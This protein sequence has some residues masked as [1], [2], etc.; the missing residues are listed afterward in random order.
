M[1]KIFGIVLFLSY[2]L[3]IQAQ[4]GIQ[5]NEGDWKSIVNKAKEQHKLIFIDVF[6]SWCGPCKRMAQDVF[7]Q[8]SVSGFFNEKF[9]NYKLDGEKGEGPALAQKY[10]V[11]GYPSFLFIDGAENVVYSAMGYMTADQ[12]LMEA[13]RALDAFNQTKTV[14]T[15]DDYEQEYL[16][17]RRE[18]QFMYDYITQ[19][20]LAQKDNGKLLEE[21]LSTQDVDQL[22]SANNLMLIIDNATQLNSKAFDVLASHL[23]EIKAKIDGRYEVKAFR[24]ISIMLSETFN[25]AV[26]NRDGS[27]LPLIL[28]ANAMIYTDPKIGA[29]KNA[30]MKLNFYKGIDDTQNLIPAV[31]DYTDRFVM[32]VPID[33]IR[34]KDVEH[35][36][37]IID[38]MQ[39]RG[40][41][42]SEDEKK[43]LARDNGKIAS[44]ESARELAESAYTYYRQ[45]K[46]KA[47][48]LKALTWA[49][50]SIE[51][52]DSHL[53]HAL[54]A[55]LLY[56]TGKE[57]KA[58]QE[59]TEAIATA[60]SKGEDAYG[61]EAELK[62]MQAKAPLAG[63]FYLN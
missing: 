47:D 18:P 33:T 38:K 40:T 59:L 5:F 10:K 39:E 29:E 6:A 7:P 58:I 27:Q 43:Q 37:Q 57:K 22:G 62:Q 15:L 60:K 52:E 11:R 55:F 56:Q 3:N 1:K 20:S 14:K 8:E 46:E 9:I 45:A 17:G 28:R 63:A 61:Y 50:R 34:Q 48:Y 35:L 21:Y 54:H 2:F 36:A 24:R 44:T 25:T 49:E 19:R 4:E 41:K 30:Q 42:L 51:L 12:F 13:T 23:G 16:Q 31:A 32:S 26:R 53:H